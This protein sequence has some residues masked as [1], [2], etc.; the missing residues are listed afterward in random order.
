MTEDVDGAAVAAAAARA[1]ADLRDLR[2]PTPDGRRFVGAS[3]ELLVRRAGAEVACQPL[4]GTISLPAN[5]DPDDYEAWLL[6]SAKNLHEH[7]V[8]VD[9]IVSLLSS[10]LRRPRRATPR[11][12]SWRCARSRTW[13][14][15]SPGAAR[16]PGDAPDALARAAR[17]APDGGRRRAPARRGARAASRASRQHDR[18]CYA[19]PV[20]WVDAN[21]DGEWW[22]GL[23]GVLV[24]GRA[25]EA[26]A[27]AGHRRR[28][29]PHRRARGDPRQARRWSSAPCWPTA[30]R[31]GA[32]KRAL[33][34]PLGDQ[35]Q[36][37]DDD[38]RGHLRLAAACGR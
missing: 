12:R 11:R 1:R 28:V 38:G 25:F 24:A 15:G 10:R 30:S 32:P 2:L 16:A 19:G 6:G 5:A 3:P 36:R 29:R 35:P 20:G 4:A 37:L 14:R 26:W 17:P 34:R 21:G 7:A 13:A 22:I 8:V 23:R 9:E 33:Q 27:G 31:A 18:G